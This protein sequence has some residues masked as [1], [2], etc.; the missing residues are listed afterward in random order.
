MR[1]K[2]LASALLLTSA[3]EAKLGACVSGVRM[4]VSAVTEGARKAE[5]RTASS[6]V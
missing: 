1:K 6:A 5:E 2:L 3:T 4:P